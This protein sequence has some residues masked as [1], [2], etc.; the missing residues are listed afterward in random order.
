MKC[1][2]VKI[3][4]LLMAIGA[5]ATFQLAFSMTGW[6]DPYFSYA[7]GISLFFLPAGVK[8]LFILVG[9][10]HALIGLTSVATYAA[11]GEWVG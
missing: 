8:L 2:K 7:Q 1:D 6:L 5:G 9:R 3:E 10:V 4:H 11:V